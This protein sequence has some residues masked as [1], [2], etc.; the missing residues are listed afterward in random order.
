MRTGKCI[1]TFYKIHAN[2]NVLQFYNVLFTFYS[3]K[4]VILLIRCY[5]QI[6]K[7]IQ[8]DKEY[9]EMSL[10]GDDFEAVRQTMLIGIDSRLEGFTKSKFEFSSDRFVTRLNCQIHYSELQILIRRLLEIDEWDYAGMLADDI[11]TIEYGIEII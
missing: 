2:A 8:M 9:F 4:F 1:L 11:V 3:C 6:T 5:K 10:V 7:E